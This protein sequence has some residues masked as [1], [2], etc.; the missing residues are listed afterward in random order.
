[1][2]ALLSCAPFVTQASAAPETPDPIAVAASP[3]RRQC[4]NGAVAVVSGGETKWFKVWGRET[5]ESTRHEWGSVSKSLTAVIVMQ[6]VEAGKLTLDTPVAELD[7]EYA[8]LIPPEKAE[9]ALTLG[10]LLSHMGGITREQHRGEPGMFL[11][12]PGAHFRYS[13]NGYAIVGDVIEAVT[14]APYA[15]AVTD[16]G[17]AAAAPSLGL[18][19]RTWIAPGALVES[20]V[21]D[22]AKFAARLMDHTLASEKSLATLWSPVVTPPADGGWLGEHADAYGYGFL[23]A[24]EGED[25]VVAHGGHNR[26]NRAFLYLRPAQH[27]GFV[28]FCTARGG[29]GAKIGWW[30]RAEEVLGALAALE[31]T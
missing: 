14:G 22:F 17:I 3:L 23:V 1:M 18:A 16:I 20:D 8:S 19:G 11:F 31:G 7:P 6:L 24:G 9:P 30:E 12:R 13:T 15:H 10:H 4:A 5:T 25:L 2:L 26:E 28:G 21:F 27:R 29:A